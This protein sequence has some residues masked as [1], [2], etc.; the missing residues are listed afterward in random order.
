[1]ENRAMTENGEKPDRLTVRRNSEREL[2]FHYN[3][4]ERLKMK[5]EMPAAERKRR[6]RVKKITRWLYV[7]LGAAILILVMM[8]LYKYLFL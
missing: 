7:L 3:R 6:T 4:D 5:G 2:H 1:M 8:I